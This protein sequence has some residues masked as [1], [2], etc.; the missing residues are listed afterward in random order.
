MPMKEVHTLIIGSGFGGIKSAIE[1]KKLGIEEFVILERNAG[2]GGTWYINNYPGAAVDVQ[3]YLYSYFDEPFNWSQKFCERDEILQYINQITEKYGLHKYIQFDKNV[4]GLEFDSEDGKWEVR[5]V[6]G[7]R[8]RAKFIINCSGRRSQKY[9]PTIPG[10]D[11][12]TIDHFH[13]STWPD[14]CLKG[15]KVGII[16]VGASA[17]QI[18]P[19]IYKDCEELHVFKRSSYW[20]LPRKNQPFSSRSKKIL[21]N[22]TLRKIYRYKLFLDNESRI[23]AYKYWPRILKA[24]EKKAKKF[25]DST[26]KNP[27]KRKI[28]TPDYSLGCKRVILSDSMYTALDADNVIIH[29]DRIKACYPEGIR[30][31]DGEKIKLDV[32]ILATGFQNTKRYI[33]FEIKAEDVTLNEIWDPRPMAFKGTV[34]KGMPNLFFMIGPNAIIGHSSEIYALESQL[35]YITKILKDH[36][37]HRWKYFDLK[38]DLMEQYTAKIDEKMK[39]TIWQTGSCVSWYHDENGV[40]TTLYPSFSFSFRKSLKR[41]NPKNFE[42]THELQ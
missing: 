2:F 11:T 18:I 34:V 16:G 1:L 28:L 21:G 24:Y 42:F 33:P 19:E 26:V 25:I 5:C 37:N 35:M 30:C 14:I 41:F 7:S 38:S 39:T 13:A 32:L 22:N 31:K 8:F 4:A 10:I 17:A 29:S 23:L 12:L 20:A 6:D 36:L 27:E 40:N 15:K 3:S 9:M